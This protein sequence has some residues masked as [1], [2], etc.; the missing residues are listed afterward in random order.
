MNALQLRA[1]FNPRAREGRDSRS[2]RS[3]AVIR[4][5]NP[6]AR[7]GRDFERYFSRIA[8]EKFQSTRPRGARRD[9]R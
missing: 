4:G 1:G 9:V 2:W 5:F 3:C 7:E 6:R 8:L